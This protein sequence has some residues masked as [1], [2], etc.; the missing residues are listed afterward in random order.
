MKLWKLNLCLFGEGG[1]E[2]GGDG[3]AA[4]GAGNESAAPQETA[5]AAQEQQ[6]AQRTPEERAKAFEELIKGEYAEE[7][8]QRTQSIVNKRFKET[9]NLEAQM[10]KLKPV[11]N[12]LS[13]KYGE[14]DHDKLIAAVQADK[15]FYQDAADAE[16]MTVEQYQE[17]ETLREKAR[18][19]DQ[20]LSERNRLE[21]ER[22]AYAQWDAQSKELK[23]TYPGFDFA[24]E[25]RNEAT[26]HTFIKLLGQGVPVEMAYKAIHA[27]ELLSGAIQTA[28]NTT[29]QRTM[30][31]IRAQGMRPDE[32][33]VGGSVAVQTKKKDPANMTKAE[34]DEYVRR[35]ARGERITFTE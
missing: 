16:G 3:A 35:A 10:E 18:A 17:R 7:F 32:N 22:Q 13:A 25:C 34:R 29:R 9:K 31:T 24:A 26:G 27:D 6:T 4:S 20:M 19:Y 8:N 30:E 23:K 11:L 21:T 28:V 12:A 14:S 2:G 15:S 33:G 1:G 5:G